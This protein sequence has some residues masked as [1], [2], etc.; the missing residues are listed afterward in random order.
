MVTKDCD[1]LQKVADLLD[2]VYSEDY[3]TLSSYGREGFEWEYTDEGVIKSIQYTEEEA[4]AQN[5]SSGA[6]LWNGVLPRVQA[7]DMRS[8]IAGCN[9]EKGKATL[10]LTQWPVQYPD[11]N[12]IDGIVALPTVEESERINTIKTNI[13]TASAE[14]ATKL[15]MGQLGTDQIEVEVKKLEDMGLEE[16]ITIYQA[17][18]ERYLSAMK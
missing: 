5:I 9:E 15:A 18:Y 14:L 7:T 12:Q 6:S 1:D 3:A 16:L 2:I 10:D 17:R 11:G 13:E 4:V 8:Q